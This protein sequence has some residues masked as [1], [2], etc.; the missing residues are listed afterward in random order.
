LSYEIA[1]IAL[2]ALLISL[3]LLYVW[4]DAA[5]NATWCADRK[6]VLLALTTL[7]LGTPLAQIFIVKAPRPSL[8]PVFATIV[9]GAA[10]LLPV[11]P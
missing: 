3:P 5:K 11:G 9:P 4:V 8:Q 6:L 2:V 1:L 7:A 10:L